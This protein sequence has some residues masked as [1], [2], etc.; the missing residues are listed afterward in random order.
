MSM[1]IESLSPFKLIAPVCKQQG[2]SPHTLQ[3]QNNE[4]LVND[5]E[6]QDLRRLREAAD[7]LAVACRFV[8]AFELHRQVWARL[9]LSR[10]CPWGP[11]IDMKH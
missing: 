11:I 1:T 10:G 2:S 8:P 5:L 4:Y 3:E 6:W 7:I 9:K